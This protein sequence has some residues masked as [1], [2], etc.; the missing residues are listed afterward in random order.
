[1]VSRRRADYCGTG[2]GCAVGRRLGAGL[3][4]FVE[5]LAQQRV[6][7]A[8]AGA[9]RPDVALA[10]EALPRER[11]ARA[12]RQVAGGRALRAPALLSAFRGLACPLAVQTPR[13]MR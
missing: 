2:L 3:E 9:S 8:V 6:L 12:S 5:Q 13:L 1:L 10:L 7:A 4:Q 11:V